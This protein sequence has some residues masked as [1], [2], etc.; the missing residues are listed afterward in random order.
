MVSQRLFIT[1]RNTSPNTIQSS[2]FNVYNL[3]GQKPN[4]IGSIWGSAFDDL[5]SFVFIVF[6]LKSKINSIW[7]FEI[8][9][10]SKAFVFSTTRTFPHFLTWWWGRWSMNRFFLNIAS[11]HNLNWKSI[12]LF[13]S[14][15]NEEFGVALVPRMHALPSRLLVWKRNMNWIWIKLYS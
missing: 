8:T 6:Y 1:W 7:Y 9:I 3:A 15:Q 2:K 12:T 11:K 4:S 14:K 13:R 5:L 10:L